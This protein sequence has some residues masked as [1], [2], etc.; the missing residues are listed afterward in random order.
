MVTRV[1]RRPCCKERARI[2][3]VDAREWLECCRRHQSCAEHF[4]DAWEAILDR[5]DHLFEM[6]EAGQ[7]EYLVQASPFRGVIERGW[8]GALP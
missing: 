1:S 2:P 4:L 8:A 6:I 5:P 7:S 3:V